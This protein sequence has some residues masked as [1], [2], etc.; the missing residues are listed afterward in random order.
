M[1]EVFEYDPMLGYCT[2]KRKTVPL[3]PV[4]TEPVSANLS[5][6]QTKEDTPPPTKPEPETS[7]TE[8]V[9]APL[10]EP[11]AEIQ[12]EVSEVEQGEAA[13]SSGTSSK[14]NQIP[15]IVRQDTPGTALIPLSSMSKYDIPFLNTLL[16]QKGIDDDYDDV[17]D[18]NDDDDDDDDDDSRYSGT[19]QV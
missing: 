16:C 4:V 7:L 5:F 6:L 18:D 19:S 17:D 10:S 2:V 12:Q 14:E 3:T 13:T 11:E 15:N 8:P 9:S 1:I